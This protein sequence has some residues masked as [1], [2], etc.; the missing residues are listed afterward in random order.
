MRELILN[1]D[2][3]GIRQA[4]T[5]NPALANEGIPYDAANPT[6]AHPLHRICDGV[7]IKKITDDEAIKIA[8]IFLEY[9]A[10]IN[11]NEMIEKKDTPLIAAASLHADQ[12]AIFYIENGADIHHAGTH[13]GTA[14][15][16]AAWCGRPSVV[17]RLL[18]GGAELNRRCIDFKSTPLF[19]A[20]HGLKSGN[21]KNLPDYQECIKY[22][23]EAGA[24]KTIPNADGKTIFDLLTDEDAVLKKQLMEEKK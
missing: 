8:K 6:K 9:G 20:V 23:L 22:L 21:N 13:G 1:K 17:K 11:G 16:W 2:Y 5:D 4:L 24:D 10:R 19:W 18:K 14:L 15:H 3:E 7:F 12:L